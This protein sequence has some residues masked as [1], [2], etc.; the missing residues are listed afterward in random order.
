MKT[1]SINFR[2]LTESQ[3]ELLKLRK[4][5][6]FTW[7]NKLKR[8]SIEDLEVVKKGF[9][10]FPNNFVVR[11]ESNSDI[12]ED[13][14][15]EIIHNSTTT[16]RN[17][18]NWINNNGMWHIISSIAF[19]EFRTGNHGMFL[20]PEFQFGSIY[21]ADYLIVG[22]NSMGMQFIFVELESLNGKITTKNG[23]EFGEVI[24]K[25]INQVDTWKRYIESN[26]HCLQPEF[27]KYMLNTNANLPYQMTNYEAWAFHYI[28]VAG[29][30]SD[31]EK[32]RYKQRN[33]EVTLL[34]YENLYDFAIAD[35]ENSRF[36]ANNRA[37]GI[38]IE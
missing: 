33:S 36:V 17:I 16:E 31:F 19:N 21:K 7:T 5:N 29:K 34:H 30:R 10:P 25:G 38:Y 8:F 3:Q 11:G 6:A 15:L 18:L 28:V 27:R 20:F 1:N 24:R 22:I 35:K 14:F 4:E 12:L 26:F 23:T 9:S 13:V 37:K 2:N 32:L